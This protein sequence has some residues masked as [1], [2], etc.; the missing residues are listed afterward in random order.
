MGDLNKFL[1]TVHGFDEFFGYLYHFD[2][3]EDPFHPQLSAGAQGQSWPAQF[4]ALRGPPRKTTQP[5]SRGG[6]KSANRRIEDE[7]PL[8]PHPIEG[9]KYNMETVDDTILDNAL[10]FADKAH[11]DGK[12][13]FLWLN[14]T[15]MHIV[16]HLSEKYESHA[17]AGK[18]LE[19]RRRRHGA[20]G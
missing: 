6:A 8:P 19:H 3:M 12:P 10:K 17:H 9:I 7:G 16:T 13:F 5:S 11:N 18:W 4:A 20:I 14:P 15:R 2:A 1:P